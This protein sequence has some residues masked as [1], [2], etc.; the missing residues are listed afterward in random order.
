MSL[1]TPK[2]EDFYRHWLATVPCDC[3]P[4]LYN[5]SH[6]H[7]TVFLMETPLGNY[8]TSPPLRSPVSWTPKMRQLAKVEPCP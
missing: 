7:Q 8:L 3:C 6:Q 2:L 1:L 4:H 5:L